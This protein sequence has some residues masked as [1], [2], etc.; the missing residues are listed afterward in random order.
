MER[1]FILALLPSIVVPAQESGAK[2]MT[3]EELKELLDKNAKMIFIDVR[4]PRE[5]KEYGTIKGFV[6]I[7]VAQFDVAARTETMS[8][9]PKDRL[10]VVACERGVRA[11]RAADVLSKNGYSQV[12]YLGLEDYRK[13]NYPHQVKP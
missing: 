7:P 6:N 8:R 13:K 4:E 12:V 2:P 11:K 9:I 3:S 1:R 10:V 5:L